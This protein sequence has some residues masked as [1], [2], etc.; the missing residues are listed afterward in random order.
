[1][2]DCQD[3][4]PEKYVI[5]PVSNGYCVD[6]GKLYHVKVIECFHTVP[7][8][9]Y[10]FYEK[11]NKLK[12]E[13]KNLNGTELAAL[14]KQNVQV[15]EQVLIPLFAFLG[16]TVPIV[17]E[18]YPQ[19]FE[20]PFVITE[21]TFLYGEQ[22][23]DKGHTCWNGLQPFIEAHPE[24]TFV[25]VHWSCSHKNEEIRDFFKKRALPNAIPFGVEE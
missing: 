13:Y 16:D 10:L 9:G 7:S 5:H 18:K 25:L 4:A 17:F 20:F 3:D 6:F 21:C 1:M 2:N 22:A 23:D 14:K 24:C 12:E 8:V 15:V 11:R 19:L